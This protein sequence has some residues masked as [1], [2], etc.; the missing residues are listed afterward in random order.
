M[1]LKSIF[2]LLLLNI[3]LTKAQNFSV[4]SM[5]NP[6]CFGDCDGSIT[7]TTSLVTGPFTAVI[8]N[9]GSCPNST[10]QN[11]T[12]NSITISGICGCAD[13]YTIA[14]YNPSMALVGSMV[15]QFINYANSP[16]NINTNTVT[17]ATCSN[18][19]D[20]NITFNVSGGNQNTAPTFSIDGTYTANV[21][22]LYFACVGTH[23][24]CV[25]DASDCIVCK[26]FFMSYQGGP[27]GIETMDNITDLMIYPNPA[28]EILYIRSQ[29]KTQGFRIEFFDQTGKKT[30]ETFNHSQF[31]NESK[32]DI[33]QLHSGIYF[34]KI[35]D[36]NGILIKKQKFLKIQ[37]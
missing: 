32:I 36:S 16:L 30:M 7:Y 34:L 33:S 35:Y 24:I 5:N 26:T 12:I 18:C 27:T 23:T 25:K 6:R 14:I 2:F 20:G 29:D 10:V 28:N 17:V 15:Q 11:S 1:N 22:P 3:S 9:T 4:A 8:T 31:E 19:C 13:N 21:N 37:N